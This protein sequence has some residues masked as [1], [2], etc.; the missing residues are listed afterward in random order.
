VTICWYL[1]AVVQVQLC[2]YFIEINDTERESTVWG[3]INML[4]FAMIEYGQRSPIGTRQER[5]LQGLMREI[6]R[7]TGQKQP[8]QVGVPLYPFSHH[9][10]FKKDG[11]PQESPSETSGMQV[12][13]PIS[14]SFDT[15]STSTGQ[16]PLPNP[17]NIVVN[18]PIGTPSNPHS[19]LGAESDMRST[20]SFS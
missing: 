19:N 9:S 7:L 14:P 4:R 10:L 6:V 16:T 3:E 2:K 12:P 11:L 8:L 13:L 17:D 1:A 5:L 18:W 15:S 20:S